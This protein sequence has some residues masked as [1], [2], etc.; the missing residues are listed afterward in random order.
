MNERVSDLN[1]T[2]QYWWS[3]EDLGQR[4]HIS[5]KRVREILQP[6]KGRC[7]KARRGRHPRLCLWVPIEVVRVLDK[8]R[9]S[10]REPAA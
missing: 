6:F 5:A 10:Y 2:A 1:M 8:D 9:E 3:V 4:Y 7:H